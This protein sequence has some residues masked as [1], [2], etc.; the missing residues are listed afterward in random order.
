MEQSRNRGT[1]RVLRLAP[2]A[3][4]HHHPEDATKHSGQTALDLVHQVAVA[5][6]QNEARAEGIVQRAINELKAAEERIRALETRALNA[7]SR[8]NEAEKWLARLHDAIQEKLADGR[9][10]QARR[11]A[12]TS[13]AA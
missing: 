8:A 1:D 10:D 5:I 2:A 12:G 4:S 7:E 11:T 3:P 13:K 9:L 6:A